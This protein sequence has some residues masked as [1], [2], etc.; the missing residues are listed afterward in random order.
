MD[1]D[2]DTLNLFTAFEERMGELPF[3]IAPEFPF[4]LSKTYLAKYLG[5]SRN[6]VTKYHHLALRYLRNYKTQ[7]DRIGHSERVLLTPFQLWVL[8]NLINLGKVWRC[9]EITKQMLETAGNDY[10]NL[11]QHSKIKKANEQQ[12]H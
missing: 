6:T 11:L 3:V 2:R 4:A 8:H 12:Q 10:F 5:V 9:D 1:A 7:Q